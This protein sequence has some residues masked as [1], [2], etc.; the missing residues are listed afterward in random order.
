M[1]NIHC[2][3]YERI[4]EQLTSDKRFEN[5]IDLIVVDNSQILQMKKVMAQQ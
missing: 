5:K 1:Q 2:T 4:Q 3:S